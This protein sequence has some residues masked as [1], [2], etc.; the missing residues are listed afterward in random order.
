MSRSTV[1][2]CAACG[3]SLPTYQY[4]PAIEFHGVAADYVPRG[5]NGDGVVCGMACGN[6]LAMRI[7]VQVP[8]VLA[9]IDSPVREIRAHDYECRRREIIAF[10]RAADRRLIGAPSEAVNDDVIDE[11]IVRDADGGAR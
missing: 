11:S 5:R 3:R 10:E 6:R 8:G 2:K 7:L 9:L 1:P 4:A